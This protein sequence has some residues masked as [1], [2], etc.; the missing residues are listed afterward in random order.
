MPDYHYQR[1]INRA[2]WNSLVAVLCALVVVLIIVYGREAIRNFMVELVSD[3]PEVEQKEMDQLELLESLKGP[4]DV[5]EEEKE[6]QLQEL[7]TEEATAVS[8]E[9]RIKQLESLRQP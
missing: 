8:E 1:Y 6:M 4:E 3:K 9:E 5:T 7:Q 2:F